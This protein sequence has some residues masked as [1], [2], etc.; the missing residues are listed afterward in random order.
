MDTTG[1]QWV[2]GYNSVPATAP[3]CPLDG[4]TAFISP[5][6]IDLLAILP[7]ANKRPEG[8]YQLICTVNNAT[9]GHVA[10]HVAK[11]FWHGTH[12]GDVDLLVIDGTNNNA[13]FNGARIVRYAGMVIDT[14]GS[15][16]SKTV[17]SSW[18]R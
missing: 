12:A 8:M 1:E 6:K 2:K 18:P 14:S 17:D 5:G 9:G 16:L 13:V 11:E 10:E 7:T 4:E 15:I 3:G